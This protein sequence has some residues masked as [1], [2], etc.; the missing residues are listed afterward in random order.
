VRTL[1]AILAFCAALVVAGCGSEAQNPG[2]STNAE[3]YAQKSRRS[4]IADPPSAAAYRKP[5]AEYR[6]HVKQSLGEMLGH[7]DAMAAAERRG[8]LAA[9]KTAWLAADRKYESIGAAYGA[10]GELNQRI[11]GTTAGV[12]GGTSSKQW[13]GLH[14]IEYLLWGKKSA[15][16]AEHPTAQLRHDVSRLRHRSA[17]IE[18]D[19]L[20]YSLRAHEVLE[21]TLHVQL[22]GR[23]SQWSG[24]ALNALAGNIAGTRV[25]LRTLEPMINQRN[26]QALRLADASIVRLQSQLRRTKGSGSANWNTLPQIDRERINGYTAAA[27]EQLAFVPG[28][29]DPRPPRAAQRAIGGT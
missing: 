6:V 2:S 17:K 26:A 8:D 18:I 28:L 27:A 25:V 5:I 16:A 4:G 23:A 9:A 12:P 19:P 15:A 24:G 1:I 29:I 3:T 13:K 7:V 20:E 11:N 22:A 14:R 10:F 21:D